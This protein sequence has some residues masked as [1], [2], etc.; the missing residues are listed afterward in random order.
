MAKKAVAAMDGIKTSSSEIFKITSLIND[1]AF[2]T[3][4]LALN[5]G[6]EA[7]RA[8]E[9]GRGFAVVATEVRALAQRSSD[10]A[11]E[12]NALISF[13]SD[14]VKDGVDLVDRTGRALDDIVQ[15]VS[16]I[17]K[18]VSQ[19]AESS[20][21][22]AAGLNEINTSVVELD[23]VTQQNAAMFDKTTTASQALTVKADSLSSAV[24]QFRLS[25]VAAKPSE[26]P[27]LNAVESP[28]TVK[29]TFT[30]A[31]SST[32]ESPKSAFQSQRQALKVAGSHEPAE[33]WQDF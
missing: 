1:I 23:K 30:S 10:A 14:Q 6:V 20:R 4:L 29:E 33:V 31:S 12:I 22:Q 9:A 13:S 26:K 5:A 24:S 16:D 32:G 18:R 19:I 15:A 11:S 21:E 3:N 8:G 17:T 28:R 2:Q 27:I 7:A 25:G